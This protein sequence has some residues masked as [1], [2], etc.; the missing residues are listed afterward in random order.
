L[1]VEEAKAVEGCVKTRA[2]AVRK[3]ARAWIVLLAVSVR[4][5][6]ESAKSLNQG[7]GLMRG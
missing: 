2:A 4:P 6:V 3:R 5:E 1:Q 7:G